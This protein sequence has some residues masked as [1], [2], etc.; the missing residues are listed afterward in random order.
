MDANTQNLFER[1]LTRPFSQKI[2]QLR[3]RL[4]DLNA[5]LNRPAMLDQYPGRA[6]PYAFTRMYGPLPLTTARRLSSAQGGAG[7]EKLA[8]VVTP[9]D[10]YLPRNGNINVGRY[11]SFVWTN[12]SIFSY[13]SLTYSA[14]PGISFE[15]FG[16]APFLSVKTFAQEGD[17]FD[18]VLDNNGGA[19]S[20]DGNSY[21]PPEKWYNFPYTGA[22]LRY[23]GDICF[24]IGLYDKLRGRFLHDQ[25][26][27]TSM[28]FSGKSVVNKPLGQEIR[29][30]ANTE[31]EPRIYLNEFRMGAMLDTDQ[32]FNAA[33]ARAY[34]AVVF[35]GR[36]EQQE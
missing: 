36:L 14:D 15:P 6:V 12:A 21:I 7:F 13:L 23:T 26:R 25:D 19:I 24:D 2:N 11:G 33:Q 20:F 27:V 9:S 22:P 16:A 28:L 10:F 3:N 18:S 8:T 35:L 5:K 30:D 32:A 29:F 31:L 17:I 1:H 34:I 4:A